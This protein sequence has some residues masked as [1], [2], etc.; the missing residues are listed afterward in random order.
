MEPVGEPLGRSHFEEAGDDRP[1]PSRSPAGPPVLD[2]SWLTLDRDTSLLL[3]LD[4]QEGAMADLEALRRDPFVG[5]VQALLRAAVR[6]GLPVVV[7]ELEPER[8]GPTLAALRDLLPVEPLPRLDYSVGSSQLVARSVARTGRRQILLAGYGA[9]A[10]IFQTARDLA[11]GGFFPF[12]VA[13]AALSRHPE[14]QARG[15]ALC[16]RAG[17]TITCVRAALLDLLGRAGTPEHD[18]LAPIAD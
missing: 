2:P 7:S 15:I 9:H 16:Q 18:E 10:A 14:D 17:A 8:R 5:S 3:L 12:V 1:H 6:L 13:D 11:L 4:V